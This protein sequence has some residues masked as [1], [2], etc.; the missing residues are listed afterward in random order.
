MGRRDISERQDEAVTDNSTR[1]IGFADGLGDRERSIGP[2]DTWQTFLTTIPPDD[3]TPSAASSF[4]SAM[5]S[6][7]ASNLDSNAPSSATSLTEPT[8]TE[9]ECDESATDADSSDEEPAIHGDPPIERN[10]IQPW[11]SMIHSRS[12]ILHHDLEITD[13]LDDMQR[14]IAGLA[15]RSDIPDDWWAG[16][17]LYRHLPRRYH[18]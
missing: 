11:R 15:Q 17:G 5:A 3:R 12:A 6:A 14:I 8:I 9:H 2:E 10:T 18:D 4:T 1:I 16:A 13:E 7:S